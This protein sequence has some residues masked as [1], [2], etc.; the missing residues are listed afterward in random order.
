VKS[1]VINTNRACGRSHLMINCA[2][3]FCRCLFSQWWAAWDYWQRCGPRHMPA[4]S[5]GILT[6]STIPQSLGSS[7]HGLGNFWRLLGFLIALPFHSN[8]SL[9]APAFNPL[10]FLVCAVAYAWWGIV[11]LY[12]PASFLKRA[13]EPW[14]RLPSWVIK[15]FGSL[16]V[17]GAVRFLFGFVM[18]IRLL[19]R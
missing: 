17:L 16:L 12:N 18:K 15:V 5:C 1:P 9:L 7:V 13:G 4:I 8:W 11:L 3:C 10:F 2:T 6:Q 19:L 14:N